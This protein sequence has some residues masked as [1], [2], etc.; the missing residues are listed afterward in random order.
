MNIIRVLRN[1]IVVSALVLLVVPAPLL[2]GESKKTIPIRI[3]IN[4]DWNHR[5][6]G[7]TRS[8]GTFMVN[9]TGKAKLTEE[10]G[11]HLKYEPDGIQATG[12]YN[13][14]IVMEKPESKCYQQVIG[15]IEASGTVP[16]TSSGEGAVSGRGG[17]I[18]ISKNLGHLG[19]IAAMQYQGQVNTDS[20]LFPKKNSRDDN[21]TA[22]LV[23]GFKATIKNGLCDGPANIR[24]GVIPVVLTIFKELDPTGMHGSYSWQAEATPPPSRIYIG[25]FHDD[26]RLGPAKGK[27]AHCRVGWTFGEVKPI[28]QIWCGQKNITDQKSQD[29]LVGQKIELEAVVKPPGFSLSEPKWDIDGDK[30]GNIVGGWVATKENAHVIPVE[31][32]SKRI[33]FCWVDGAF[34]GAPMK[35]KFSGAV[36]G[37]QVDAKTTFNVFKP[38]INEKKVVP[39]KKV[40]VG[41]MP[42]ETVK[43]GV[44]SLILTN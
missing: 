26:I 4:I 30:N 29:V 32:H 13:E 15:R 14:R 17:S 22:F 19:T 31:R 44:K 38:K 40:T 33:A 42:D 34:T 5:G 37:Q 9:V 27:G 21:Y 7:N 28:V 6:S 3:R 41:L 12:K 16:I 39:A 43:I 20:I 11:E 25:D 18:T 35:L 10:K 23:A 24:E 1:A 36:D 2:A 8:I